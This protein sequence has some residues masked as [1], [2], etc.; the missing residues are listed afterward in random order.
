MASSFK[1][2]EG[3]TDGLPIDPLALR[4]EVKSKYRAVAVEPHARYHFHP[5]RPLARRLGYGEAVVA[6]LPDSAVEAFAGVGNP[7]SL[8]TLKPGER[9]I[10]LGSGGGFDCFV[11]A[12]QAGPEGHVVGVDMTEEML[13]RSRAA[14]AAMGLRNVEFRQGVIEDLP[15]EDGSADVVIST[16]SSIFAPTS[17][18]FSLK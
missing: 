3:M 11:A 10:D 1:E 17:A 5:G 7:F 6:A 8:G 2:E 9:V 4:E 14:A 16:A 18:E 13:G 12:G 15:V